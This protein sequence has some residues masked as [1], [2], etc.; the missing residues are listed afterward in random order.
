MHDVGGHVAAK[1]VGDVILERRDGALT[2]G[3]AKTPQTTDTKMSE[4][5]QK[6]TKKNTSGN[7]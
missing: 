5:K 4:K 2:V 7:H 1:G 3:D 6:K